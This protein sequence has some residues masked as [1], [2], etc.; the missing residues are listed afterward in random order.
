IYTTFIYSEYI[1]MILVTWFVYLYHLQSIH[2][3]GVTQEVTAQ[4]SIL[5]QEINTLKYQL[6]HDNLTGLKN[7]DNLNSM[8]KDYIHTSDDEKK[9]AVLFI[10]LDRFKKVNDSFGHDM[11]DR[12]LQSITKRFLKVINEHMHL[13][14]LSGDE[15]IILVDEFAHKQELIAISRALINISKQPFSIKEDTVFLSCS[16]GI[17]IYPTDSKNDFELM[18]H[19]D[20]AMFEAKKQSGKGYCFYSD[21]MNETNYNNIILETELHYALD[22]KELE[23]YYQPQVDI[24][25]NKIIGAEVLLRWNHKRLGFLRPGEFLDNAVNSSLITLIDEY[26]FEEGMKQVVKW[27]RDNINLGRVSFNITIKSLEDERI[28]HKIEMLLAK[29]GCKGEWIEL[30]ILEN[31]IMFDIEKSVK[32]LKMFKNLGIKISLD[33][34]GVGYSS[35]TYLKKLPIDKIKV[36]RSF[37]I[38]ITS[39]KEDK[40]V[41]D[42]IIAIS[43]TLNVNL[44]IEGVET[45]KQYTYFKN[46]GCRYMQG[47]YCY[48]PMSHNDCKALLL[49]QT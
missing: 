46:I 49:N 42:A 4:S 10:D 31:D 26:V 36:D 34:F 48:T 41:V 22:N 13:F 35:L 15:F 33:D 44:I 1:P 37:V 7:R 32:V 3:S 14:R 40:A 16:I 17:S 47:N 19:A 38:E 5:E 25:E 45:K 24:V 43:K 20:T 6:H 11:G 18:K 39:N 8:L 23:L 2:S 30:E 12:I 27:H 28:V 29:T 9:F 21:D